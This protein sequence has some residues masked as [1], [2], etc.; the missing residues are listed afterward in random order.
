MQHQGDL[1]DAIP[2][3]SWRGDPLESV[4]SQP[5]SSLPT[6]SLH[7]SPTPAPPPRPAPPLPRTPTLAQGEGSG[8]QRVTATTGRG[9]PEASPGAP[10]C[11]LESVTR[12]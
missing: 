10:I 1:E 7:C 8:G 5:P 6:E 3:L 11:A 9:V 2:D 4:N 12:H